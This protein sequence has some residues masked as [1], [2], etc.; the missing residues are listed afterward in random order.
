MQ[1]KFYSK[2]IANKYTLT[3]GNDA[4]GRD[5]KNWTLAGSNDEA[6]WV[7]LDTRTDESFAGRNET[8]E[9]TFNYP[10]AYKYYR[11]YITANNGD[12]L[13]QLSEWRLLGN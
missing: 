8:R 13:F 3:S 6:N 5:P 2:A 4:P 12:G 7:A 9:F 11:F 10:T 1:Q